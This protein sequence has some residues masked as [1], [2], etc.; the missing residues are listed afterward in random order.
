M[1]V[2][3]QI[4]LT[5]AQ[6]HALRQASASNG[7]SIAE[8]VRQGVELYL[9]TQHQPDR[10]RQI[11]RALRAAGKYSSGAKDVSANHDRYLAEAFRK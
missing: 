3:T 9:D 1:M 7:R 2:R 10:G 6:L 5:D 8:L 11:E 4:Q